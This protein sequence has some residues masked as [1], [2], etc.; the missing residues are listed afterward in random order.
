M[1]ESAGG[2]GPTRG[3]GRTGGA[4]AGRS[5]ALAA[6]ASGLREYARTPVLLALF[7]FLPAYLIG[8]FTRLV[9]ST[10]VPVAVPGDGAVP[11]AMADVY[12]VFMTPL[13]GALV[14]A[15]AGIFLLQSTRAADGRLVVAGARPRQVLLARLGLLAAVGAVVAGVAVAT[16]AT[17]FVPERPVVLF[18]ATLLGALVYGL[19][20]ALAGIV[21][22]RLAGVY[23][24]LF[25]TMIDVFLVQNP[26]AEAPGYAVALPGYAPVELAVD[27][28]FSASVSLDP[29][30]VGLAWVVGL[31]V[32][33]TLVLARQL[34]VG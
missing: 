16:A 10:T 25:G 11:L 24:A 34:R 7:L 3:R 22:D 17:A 13:V 23:L 12:A 19:L 30:W 15:L 31:G 1:S 5:P 20:G 33:T 14:G 9:P 21:V 8:A 6:F 29:V 2:R 32:V 27:A 28:G 26:L 18:G 4:D